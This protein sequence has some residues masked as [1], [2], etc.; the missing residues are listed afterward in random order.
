VER[1]AGAAFDAGYRRVQE[2]LKSERYFR[3]LDNLEDFRDHPPVRA[4]AVAPG[5]KIAGKAVDKSARRLRRSQ[6]AARNAR[7][8]TDHEDALH[9]VRKDAKRL[10]HVAESAALV[11]GKRA[12]K[13][14][15][16]AHKQQKI[17]GDFRDALIARNLLHDLEAGSGVPE[18]T[19][20][21]PGCPAGAPGGTDG[22]RRGQVPKGPQEVPRPAAARGHLVPTRTLAS[23]PRPGNPPRYLPNLASSIGAPR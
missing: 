13:V 15:K 6:K 7:R 20:A 14:V 18:S 12:G 19:D 21:G 11:T 22:R 1:K 4:E 17:L 9:Q 23:R 10:R 3:L 2:A 16:A 5:R 8:G